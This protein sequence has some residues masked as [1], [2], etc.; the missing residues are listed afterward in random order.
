MSNKTKKATLADFI[1]KATDKEDK[2]ETKEVRVISIDKT[3][4]IR[5]L[6]QDKLMELIDKVGDKGTDMEQGDK[7][8]GYICYECVTEPNL[9]E[10]LKDAEIQKQLGASSPVDAVSK[11][12]NF[13]ER[14]EITKAIMEFSDLNADT[15]EVLKN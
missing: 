1:S 12:L 11:M 13:K 7:L 6:S 15:I 3:I 4:I 8:N 9:K 10:E 2:I 14:A 5:N